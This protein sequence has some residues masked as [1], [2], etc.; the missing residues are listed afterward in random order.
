MHR[1]AMQ[2]DHPLLQKK[3]VI[4]VRFTNPTIFVVLPPIS[5]PIV[6]L[7]LSLYS[8]RIFSVLA[9]TGDLFHGFL[10]FVGQNDFP[11][12]R[13]GNQLGYRRCTRYLAPHTV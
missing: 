6:T 2:W 4:I 9:Y 8:K 7:I 5:I 10:G 11:G 13:V 12:L 3:G 1:I